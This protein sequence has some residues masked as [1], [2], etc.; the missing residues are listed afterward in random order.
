MVP[1]DASKRQEPSP[2]RVDEPFLLAPPPK[3]ARLIVVRAR[4]DFHDINEINDGSETF[5]F[6][7]L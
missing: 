2:N 4:F 6:G 7:G 5:E 1:D 3:D